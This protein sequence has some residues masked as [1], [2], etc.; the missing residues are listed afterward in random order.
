MQV[1]DVRRVVEQVEQQ[2]C[3][4]VV[5][6]ISDDPQTAAA[7]PG[8][9]SEVELE[10]V[11]LVQR[12]ALWRPKLGVEQRGQVPV[13]LDRIE[14]R[15][16]IHEQTC[17]GTPSGT[18]LDQT[19]GGLGTQG[20]DDAVQDRGVVQEVLAES[21]ATRGPVVGVHERELDGLRACVG[22]IMSMAISMAQARLFASAR[23]VP[24]SSSAVP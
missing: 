14:A 23:P 1:F 13:D 17:Q 10:R 22:E 9:R 5:R 3:R 4:D 24:A 20:R 18:D 21:F 2:G 8:E 19:V 11:R 6:Q 12:E 15:G 16:P 7:R